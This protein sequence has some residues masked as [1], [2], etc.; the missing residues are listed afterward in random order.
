MKKIKKIVYFIYLND[1]IESGVYKKIRD[2]ILLWKQFHINHLLIIITSNP[3]TQESIK[4]VR[5]INIKCYLFNNYF[6]RLIQY[7]LIRKEIYR[8]KPDIVYFRFQSYS[9]DYSKIAKSFPVFVEINSNE[10]IERKAT[11]ALS[12]YYN[13]FTRHLILSKAS[14]LVF[15]SRELSNSKSYKR[16]NKSILVLGNGIDFKRI[17]K[18]SPPKN[19]NPNLVFLGNGKQIWSGIDKILTLANLFPKWHFH[20]IGIKKSELP[21]APENITLYGYLPY[22]KYIKIYEK[23]DVAIGTLALHRKNMNETSALKILEYLSCGIPV[24]IGYKETNFPN[25]EKFILRLPN[26]ENNIT[27]YKKRIETFVHNWMNKRVNLNDIEHINS[28]AIEMK[29]ISFLMENWK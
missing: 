24:I 13:V 18:I 22:D 15:V 11:N 23:I 10:S 1:G 9:P 7:R 12:Y 28:E 20:L 2:T 26:V 14:G 21:H 19:S 5:N 3:D 4:T 8:Y 27:P 16:F 6:E 17:T 25:I 29:R